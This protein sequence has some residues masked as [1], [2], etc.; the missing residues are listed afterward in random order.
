M[1]FKKVNN[2][3]SVAV[4]ESNVKV[5]GDNGYFSQKVLDCINL[6]AGMGVH[7]IK[8]GMQPAVIDVD[9]VAGWTSGYLSFEAEPLITVLNEL[10][11]YTSEKIYFDAESI[12]DLWVS[13]VIPIT[14]I[15]KSYA[16]L[17]KLLPINIKRYPYLAIVSKKD[18]K[19]VP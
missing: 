10:T 19:N 12:D 8:Q 7:Q 6:S 2:I 15:D 18:D 13:G 14:D 5:C 3:T 16:M 11:R 17:S 1:N 4:I 9:S